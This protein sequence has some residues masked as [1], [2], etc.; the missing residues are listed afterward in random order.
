MLYI[1]EG[2]VKEIHFVFKGKFIMALSCRELNSQSLQ[3]ASKKILC[4]KLNINEL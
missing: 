2:R 4:F 1:R 3:L